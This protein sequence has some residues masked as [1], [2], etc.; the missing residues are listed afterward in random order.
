MQQ[1][2]TV[3]LPAFFRLQTE[4]RV[5]KVNKSKII[6]ENIFNGD[7]FGTEGNHESSNDEKTLLWVFL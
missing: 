6:G 7:H 2:N 4:E 1:T 3:K 5:L